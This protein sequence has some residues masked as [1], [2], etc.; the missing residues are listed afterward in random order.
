MRTHCKKGHELI[1]ENI[2]PSAL[3]YGDIICR[4]CHNEQSKNYKEKKR[5]E[6]G[7]NIRGQKPFCKNGHPRIPENLIRGKRDC[8][9]CHRE[10]E[11]AR[12]RKNGAKPSTAKDRKGLSHT[13]AYKIWSKMIARCYNINNDNYRFYGGRGISVCDR[14]K[15]SFELFLLDMGQPPIGLS[16]DRKNTFGNY[17][18]NNCRWATKAEQMRNMRN[19]VFVTYQ[20][21]TF[22]VSEL[23]RKCEMST[24]KLWKRLFEYHWSIDE[25]VKG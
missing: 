13:R 2:I 15:N 25:A 9:I 21:E 24:A 16:L 5:R 8:A 4:I 17:E 1:G 12:N 20:K 23:A 3:K 18:P 22:T 10:R 7:M 19:N 14:W 11:K 6:Q